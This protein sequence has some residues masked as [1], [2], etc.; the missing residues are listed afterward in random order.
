MRITIRFTCTDISSIVNTSRVTANNVIMSFTR[1]G[2]LSRDNGYFTV[3][4]EGA[5]QAL[6]LQ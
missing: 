3:R 4:D 6:A 2:I 1:M 5:L